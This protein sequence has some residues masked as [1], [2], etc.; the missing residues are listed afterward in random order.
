M[1]FIYLFIEA[2]RLINLHKFRDS[3]MKVSSIRREVS[4]VDGSSS[5]DGLTLETS[6][7]ESPLRWTIHI[8]NP[9]DKTKL[10]RYTSHRR[11]TTVSLE[12]R[13][14]SHMKVPFQTH[15]E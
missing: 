2:I 7:F 11:S 8:I 3:H 4:S 14:S 9:V 12:T 10:S 1:L 13:P 6:P 5:D 15:N